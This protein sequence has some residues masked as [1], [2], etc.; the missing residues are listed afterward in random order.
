MNYNKWAIHLP[1]VK[2]HSCHVV[3]SHTEQPA[4]EVHRISLS[5]VIQQNMNHILNLFCSGFLVGRMTP[6]RK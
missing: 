2:D 3:A 1:F 6:R 5:G 4:S